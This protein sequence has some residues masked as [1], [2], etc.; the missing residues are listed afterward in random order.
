MYASVTID[1]EMNKITNKTVVDYSV[2]AMIPIRAYSEFFEVDGDGSLT[3]FKEA[4]KG[5]I[6]TTLMQQEGLTEEETF[7]FNI[8]FSFYNKE[9]LKLLAKRARKLRHAKFDD[10]RS[11]EAKMD[12]LK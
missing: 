4:L 5:S 10:A 7:I 6:R 9:M 12:L 8:E 2:Q 11:I 3:G 1:Y